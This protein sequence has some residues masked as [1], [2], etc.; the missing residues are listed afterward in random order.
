MEENRRGWQKTKKKWKENGKKK[1]KIK[2]S[3]PVLATP[4]LKKSESR[5]FSLSLSLSLFCFPSL[6]LSLSLLEGL[7][8]HADAQEFHVRLAPILEIHLT[9]QLVHFHRRL[10][11]GRVSEAKIWYSG[12][13][14]GERLRG[15]RNR[16]NRP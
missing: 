2:G 7:V 8:L 16:G 4:H 15:N 6:S 5:R 3:H 14:I 11:E 12:I 10:L 1:L 9:R 13:L